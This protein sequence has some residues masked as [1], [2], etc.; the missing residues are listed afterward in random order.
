M[1]QK[2]LKRVVQ[3]NNG[4]DMPVMGLGTLFMKDKKAVEGAIL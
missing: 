2:V 1:A 4:A 3:L